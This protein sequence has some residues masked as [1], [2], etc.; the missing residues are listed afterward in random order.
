MK[1]NKT[2]D[3]HIAKIGGKIDIKHIVRTKEEIFGFKP[4]IHS[5]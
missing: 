1:H 4:D 3:I 5:I 2:L